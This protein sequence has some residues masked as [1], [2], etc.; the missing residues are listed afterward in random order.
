MTIKLY[1][2]DAYLRSFESAVLHAGTEPDGV[3]YA[4]LEQTAFYP[5]GG[6]QPCDLGTLS[7]I[8]VTDV[9]EVGGQIIHRLASPLPD[10]MQQVRGEIDW[11]RRFDHMQQHTGQHILSAAFEDIYN[12]ETFGFHMGRETVTVDIHKFPLS[13]S[14]IQAVEQLAN[15]IVFENRPVTAAF[16]TTEELARVPLRKPPKVT[17]NI[18]IV[19]VQDF[20]Y[21]ACGGTHPNHTAEIGLIK[22][23]AWEKHKAGTRVEFVCGNRVLHAMDRK[24]QIL[25][26]LGR[27][28]GTGENELADSAGKMIEDRR[29]LT[30]A[31]QENRKQL[32]VHEA[33]ELIDQAQRVK[34]IRVSVAALEDRSMQELQQLAGIITGTS[35]HRIAL[36]ASSGTKTN[37]VFA[38][39]ND[40]ELSMAEL[41]KAVLPLID[42]KGGGNASLAQGGGSATGNPLYL[43]QEAIRVMKERL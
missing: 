29:E 25:R 23:L 5:T 15:R 26:E 8:P 38:K 18:R 32:L 19:T 13:E 35:G 7:G 11:S 33:K 30:K 41:L 40:V 10:G 34:D 36:L 27:L 4:I 42:G 43:L 9:Q 16:V 14:D 3:P 39:G 12:A 1:Y 28:F 6:G 24:Q 37:L 17:E 2:E 31:L 22:V 20:D 21:S